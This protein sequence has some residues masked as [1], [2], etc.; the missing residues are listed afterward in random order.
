VASH[1]LAKIS[2][3]LS[4]IANGVNRSEQILLSRQQ[5]PHSRDDNRERITRARETAEALFTSKPPVSG[6][7][8]DDIPPAGPS[9]R[10]P[11]VLRIIS[12]AAPVKPKED[13]A[14]VRPDPR[15]QR[16]IPRSQFARIRALVRYGMTAAQVAEVFGVTAGDIERI[17]RQP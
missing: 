16:E 5:Q 3:S 1:I 4:D 8:V 13:K 12:P 6:P 14:P 9:A 2:K 7:S 11:R 10:K 17:L 15:T